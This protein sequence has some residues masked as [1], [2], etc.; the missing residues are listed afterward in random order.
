[1]VWF[2]VGTIFRF[3]FGVLLTYC[4]FK[5]SYWFVVTYVK[6]IMEAYKEIRQEER[7]IFYIQALCR[8]HRATS[9][10]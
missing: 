3:C 10:E 9:V 2:I 4:F 6:D 5:V 8:A 7:R 1:M